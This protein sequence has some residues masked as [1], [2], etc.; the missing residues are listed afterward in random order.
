MQ[1]AIHNFFANDVSGDL[2]GQFARVWRAVAHH[3]AGNADVVG[4]E[5][6]NEPTDFAFGAQFD[7]ELQCFYGGAVREP[8][9][10]QDS[11]SQALPTG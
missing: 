4:Y 9:S 5:L 2:Q 8:A 1:A 6:Y 3:Y 10:C 7:A 11:G